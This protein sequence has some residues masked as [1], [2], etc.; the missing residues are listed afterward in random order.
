MKKQ[1]QLGLVIEGSV[2]SSAVLR[3]SKLAD[4]LGPVKSA[5]V[6][7]ARRLSNL[8]KAGYAVEGYEDLQ[9]SGLVLLHVPDTA[10]GRIV[11]EICSAE[12]ALKG[13]SFVL[14]ESWLAGDVLKPLAERGAST[15]T[16]M[17][18]PTPQRDWFVAE[19]ASRAV[20]LARR[21]LERSGFRTDEAKAG[22][23]DLLFASQLMATAIPIPILVTAQHA[24]RSSGFSG[25]IL[26]T[27]LEQMTMRMLQDF[28]RGGRAP[29]GGPLND[30][31]AEIS[32][33]HFQSLREKS[34][35]VAKYLGEQIVLARRVMFG[36][37]G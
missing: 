22:S 29:W 34:P 33:G 11:S 6:R 31:A 24:L 28:L 25:N 27:L 5:S 14:C 19:G 15:A 7:V 30:C 12:M 32:E 8:L 18:L 26:S 23:K 4:E 36:S 16:V 10:V 21:F 17:T 1:S 2:A 13:I 9:G 35:E 37:K 3:A 20:R